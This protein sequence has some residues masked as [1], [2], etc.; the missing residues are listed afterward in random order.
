MEHLIQYYVE[1]W[2]RSF[3]YTGRSKRPEYWWFY[4]ANFIIGLVLGLRSKASE[5]V[6]WILSLYFPASIVP[7][8]PLTIRRLRDA[9]KA[10][11]WIFIGLIPIIGAIW[12]IVLL[13]QPSA[14]QPAI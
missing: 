11:P 14:L 10:W 8:L 7:T 4:L 12:L 13:C 5:S 6:G 3:D 9:G 1:A 2:R